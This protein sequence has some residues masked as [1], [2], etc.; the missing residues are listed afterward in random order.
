M[1]FFLMH[2]K[3]PSARRSAVAKMGIGATNLVSG[4]GYAGFLGYVVLLL[5]VADGCADR[6]FC[7]DRAVDLDRRERQLLDDVGVRDREGF[8]DRF[9]LDPLG[10]E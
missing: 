1:G 9:A 2:D 7:E 5:P 3:C 10:G 4:Y 8:G 6:V